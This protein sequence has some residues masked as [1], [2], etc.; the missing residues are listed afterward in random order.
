[1]PND[2]QLDTLLPPKLPVPAGTSPFN[3]KGT[4]YSDLRFRTDKLV[5][6]G[7]D[8]VVELIDDP[9]TREFFR[10]KFMPNKW[11]DYLPGIPFSRAV[12]AAT[13]R[14][15]YE[16]LKEHAAMH[17]ERDLSGV[18]VVLLFFTSPETAMRRIPVIHKQYFDFG[19][20]EVRIIDKG[21]AETHIHG[22]PAFA[23][24]FNQIYST[25]FVHRLVVLSG[26][27]NPRAEWTEPEPDGEKNGIK[28]VRQH[29]RTTWD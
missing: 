22:W 18:Y 7:F 26:G 28:T 9:T 1:M 11:Y 6:A 23:A 3:I 29:V 14:S 13:G 8:R 12:V 15:P 2:S 5:P 20:T 16:T 25:E 21:I 4:A 17:T 10:Q 24:P 27:K 19:S